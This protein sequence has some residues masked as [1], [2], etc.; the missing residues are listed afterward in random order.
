M[1]RKKRTTDE[2]LNPYALDT[3]LYQTMDEHQRA[4]ARAI[5]ETAV[6]LIDAPSGTGKTTIAFLV[7]LEMLAKGACNKILY[8]RYP[9]DRYLGQGFLPGTLE[10]KEQ[11]LFHP[12][13]DALEE[14]GVSQIQLKSLMATE[15]LQF[16]TDV[17]MRGRNLKGTFL[18]VDEAQNAR[19]I[20]DLHLVLTRLHDQDSRAVIIGHNKQ[21][22]NKKVQLVGNSK[23]TPFT[24]FIYHMTKKEFATQAHLV[25]NYRGAIS[26]WADSIWE[27][28]KEL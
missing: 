15:Q 27:S 14:L 6:T 12:A 8:L 28:L 3:T 1:A 2:Q 13:F 18:I 16:A 22:D 11:H 26:L 23:V 21:Q 10:D 24:A 25:K 5:R 4:Y 7:G 19:S 17:T 20:D 9:D